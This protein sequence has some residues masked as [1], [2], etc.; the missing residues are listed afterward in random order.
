[1]TPER[2]EELLAKI[3]R[4][5]PLSAQIIRES[6][7]ALSDGIVRGRRKPSK[8]VLEEGK[9]V[10][11]MTTRNRRISEG[12]CRDC[13][14]PIDRTVSKCFCLEHLIAQ[15]KRNRRPL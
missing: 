8:T 3:E 12:K 15:R 9:R 2:R 10:A 7:S 14:N 1:M 13:E 5:F 11:R 6:G 4:F